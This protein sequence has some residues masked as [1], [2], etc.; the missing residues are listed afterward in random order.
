MGLY[1]FKPQFAP[2][3]LEG[4]KTHTI[5]AYRKYPDEPGDVM[6]LYTGLRTKAACLLLR[7]LCLN[8][9]PIKITRSGIAVGGI[10]LSADECDTLA[11]R[12]GFR[13]ETPEAL[14]FQRLVPSARNVR[15]V[16]PDPRV[17]GSFELMREFWTGRMPFAGALNHWGKTD[18]P[19]KKG[20]R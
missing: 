20:W 16:T 15:F 11:W 3:I 12:D 17:D 7:R 10:R 4:S 8:A 1:N 9:E 6:H 14:E 19:W 5:R 2:F 13:P 18:V